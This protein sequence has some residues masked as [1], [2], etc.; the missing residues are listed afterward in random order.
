MAMPMSKL[1]VDKAFKEINRKEMYENEHL[2]V[3]KC[4]QMIITSYPE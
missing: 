3:R 4:L 2:G 1:I